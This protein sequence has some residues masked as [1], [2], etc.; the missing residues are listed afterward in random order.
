MHGLSPSMGEPQPIDVHVLYKA[1]EFSGSLMIPAT[2][3]HVC[4][5][6]LGRPVFG[7]SYVSDR[8]SQA[9]AFEGS[10][11][12]FKSRK[13]IKQVPQCD[14]DARLGPATHEGPPRHE[15]QRWQALCGD[16]PT[17]GQG[18]AVWYP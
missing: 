15:L 8:T 5:G 12:L 14:R 3:H 2:L 11:K 7:G 9:A 6:G 4:A 10:K 1:S 13:L 16:G 17:V 18:L